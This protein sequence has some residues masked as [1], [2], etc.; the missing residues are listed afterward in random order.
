MVYEKLLEIFTRVMPQVDV[1][2]I[3]RD[4][5]LTT[6]IGV[7]S[8]NMMLLAITVEDE[9]GIQFDTTKELKTVGDICDFVE[10]HM[11]KAQV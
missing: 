10:T 8:L 9:F 5:V 11:K 3:S 7:D 6:D 4:S 1:S 2:R